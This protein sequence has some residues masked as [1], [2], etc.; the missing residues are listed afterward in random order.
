MSGSFYHTCNHDLIE[1]PLFTANSVDPDQTPHSAA[2]DLG[3]HCLPISLLWDG[4][5][6]RVKRGRC[7]LYKIKGDYFYDFLF[8]FLHT[9]PFLKRI[10]SSVITDNDQS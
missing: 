4:R 10:R 7:T 8:A 9:K 2:S 6:K 1:I 5:Y 3:L